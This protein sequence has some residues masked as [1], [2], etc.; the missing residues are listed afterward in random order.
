MNQKNSQTY[1]HQQIIRSTPLFSVFKTSLILSLLIR[2]WKR[3]VNTINI[4]ME[5]ENTQKPLPA[6]KTTVLEISG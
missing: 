3:N 2:H 1:E 6:R 4:P 5:P